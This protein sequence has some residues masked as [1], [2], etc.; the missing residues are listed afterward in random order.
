MTRSEIE[1]YNHIN[2]VEFVTDS[3]NLTNDYTRNKIRNTIIPLLSSEINTAAVEHIYSAMQFIKN[4]NRFIE[5]VIESEKHR[6]KTFENFVTIDLNEIEDRYVK[7]EL[8]R[9]AIK[10]KFCL[11]DITKRHIEDITN[12][13]E[14]EKKSTLDLPYGIKVVR[15]KSGISIGEVF[16]QEKKSIFELINENNSYKGHKFNIVYDKAKTLCYDKLRNAVVRTRQNGDYILLKKKVK[17]KDYFIKKKINIFDRDEKVLIAIGSRVIWISDMFI[18]SEYVSE[19][20]Q[21]GVEIINYE[22]TVW[23]FN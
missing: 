3:T 11:K 9:E 5:K 23:S 2:N 1:S 22:W 10:V 21:K 16:A 6:I 14:K 13:M 17:L 19:N 18:D 15:I 7:S 8:I 4:Q 20:N 12:L